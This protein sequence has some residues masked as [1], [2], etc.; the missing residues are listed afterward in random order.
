[1]IQDLCAEFAIRRTIMDLLSEAE[2]ARLCAGTSL[3]ELGKGDEYLDLVRLD[4]EVQRVS[5]RVV[6]SGTLL[7]RRG[8]NEQ[9]WREILEQLSKALEPGSP[10][11]SAWMA[12]S[13]AEQRAPCACCTVPLQPARF[14]L[15]DAATYD[16]GLWELGALCGSRLEWSSVALALWRSCQRFMVCRGSAR[17]RGAVAGWRAVGPG[18]RTGRDG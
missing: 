12:R 6:P 11:A 5:D 10:R 14:A 15:P 1:M 13:S 2:I 16:A 7:A 9:V 8:V 18:P 3:E 17:G 4:L